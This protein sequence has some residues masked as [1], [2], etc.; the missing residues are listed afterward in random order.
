M[1][2]TPIIRRLTGTQ[3]I[4]SV[5]RSCTRTFA[6]SDSDKKEKPVEHEHGKN[7][8]S[9]AFEDHHGQKRNVSSDAEA[10]V[11][12][13]REAP[14]SIDELQKNTEKAAKESHK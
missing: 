3:L 11:K 1:S 10:S 4:R 12:A 6:S 8:E 13:E 5:P 7:M 14:D 9:D 2:C